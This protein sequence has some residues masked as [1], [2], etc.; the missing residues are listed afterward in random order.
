MQRHNQK[1]ADVNNLNFFLAQYSLFLNNTK[2]ITPK[3]KMKPDNISENGALVRF[4]RVDDDQWRDGEFDLENK[5]FIEIYAAELTTHNIGDI[6]KW[7]YIK[8]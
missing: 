8:E 4:V 7:E 1:K 6:N 3:L 2:S 5:L